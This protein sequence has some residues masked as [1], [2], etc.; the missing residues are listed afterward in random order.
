MDSVI[1][2]RDIQTV[3]VL[4]KNSNKCTSYLYISTTSEITSPDPQ[5]HF[6]GSRADPLMPPK[7]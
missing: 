6:S 1:V 4:F 5:L 2:L 3:R 7:L